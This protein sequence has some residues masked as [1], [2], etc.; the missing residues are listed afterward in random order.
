M[1][2]QETNT[3]LYLCGYLNFNNVNVD[4]LLQVYRS[5]GLSE[6]PK[7]FTPPDIELYTRSMRII[8][9]DANMGDEE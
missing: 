7:C 8:E 6:P 2:G 4:S 1:E 9:V 5:L 3:F